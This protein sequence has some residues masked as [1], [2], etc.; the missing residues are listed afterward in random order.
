MPTYTFKENSKR[1]M[2]AGKKK[3]KKLTL[4]KN[5]SE[6]QAKVHLYCL[7]RVILPLLHCSS[8]QYAQICL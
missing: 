7:T 4:I 6:S 8:E 3:K 1:A 2:R 5:I